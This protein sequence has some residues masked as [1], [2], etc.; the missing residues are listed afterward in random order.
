MRLLFVIALQPPAIGGAEIKASR[1]ARALVSRGHR[2]TI[3]TRRLPNTERREIVGGVKTIRIGKE[4]DS[5]A[6]IIGFAKEIFN[7]R[8]KFNVIHNFLLSSLTNACCF[9]GKRLGK[10][11]II[12]IGGTGKFGGP[13]DT[14]GFGRLS[15]LK[16][17][18]IAASGAK[19]ICPSPQSRQEFA[20]AG[21]A[22][23]R[24]FCVPNPVDTTV[25]KPAS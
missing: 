22:E 1:L 9:A 4:T 6:D 10:P 11:V 18:H 17:R 2:V 13:R 5:R 23:N 16:W 21:I 20:S 25:F 14:S 24:V 7:R 3:L 12:S 19:F 15:W 8:E